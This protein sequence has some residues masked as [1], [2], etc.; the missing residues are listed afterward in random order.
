M[1][2]AGSS[3]CR[4]QLHAACR[5]R[6]GRRHRCRPYSQITPM[7]HIILCL[8]CIST[9]TSCDRGMDF[10]PDR[11]RLPA[12][13][14]GCRRS[15][16]ASRQDRLERTYEAQITPARRVGTRSGAGS[17]SLRA[18]A[19]HTL[20]APRHRCDRPL[21]IPDEE[22]SPEL[23]KTLSRGSVSKSVTKRPEQLS[24][25]NRN[26]GIMRFYL[27]RSMPVAAFVTGLDTPQHSMALCT[28]GTT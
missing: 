2:G 22:V 23:R 25:S 9:T 13:S 18:I 19:L 17:S 7:R 12:R 21:A 28:S 16:N 4:Q 8:N 14:C 15:W 26:R 20:H 1:D 24:L 11:R 5:G 27:A 3:G 6:G 10:R